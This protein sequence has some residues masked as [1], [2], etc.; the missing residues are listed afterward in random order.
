MGTLVRLK[1]YDQ[2]RGHVLRSYS[3]FGQRFLEGKGWYNVDD[4][5][6]AYL[7]QVKQPPTGNYQA[8]DAPYAFDVCTPEQAAALDE[9]EVR[10]KQAQ[11]GTPQAPILETTMR[12]HSITNEQA[13]AAAGVVTTADLPRPSPTKT[14]FDAL[15]ESFD[16]DMAAPAA[17]PAPT[18]RKTRR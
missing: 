8:E 5:A 7:S 14:S 16:D 4:S 18:A 11:F 13:R 17:A 15:P 1:P 12:T 2:R 10:K 9:A 3:A 6:A